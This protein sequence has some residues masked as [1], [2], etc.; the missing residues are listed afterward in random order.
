MAC[1]FFFCLTV[2]IICLFEKKQQQLIDSLFSGCD[3]QTIV[4]IGASNVARIINKD[5]P[6]HQFKH[7]LHILAH[8]G[9]RHE[10]LNN[11]STKPTFDNLLFNALSVPECQIIF[12][13]PDILYNM[14]T[15][16][17]S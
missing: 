4:I 12:I 2:V 17:P 9:C 5:S 11:Y 14:M 1:V 10:Y 8:S 7:H 16:P 3:M 13:F 15:A 6:P